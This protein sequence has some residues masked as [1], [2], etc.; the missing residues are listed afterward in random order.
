MIWFLFCYIVTVALHN[1]NYN[2]TNSFITI[3]S[4]ISI[5]CRYYNVKGTGESVRFR[6]AVSLDDVSVS[7]YKLT[8]TVLS[9]FR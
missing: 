3:I 5:L 4:F 9:D 2:I 1:Y 7:K 8:V 6:T